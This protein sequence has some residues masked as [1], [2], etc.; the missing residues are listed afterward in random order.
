MQR[1]PSPI[2]TLLNPASPTVQRI[3][4]LGDK[5]IRHKGAPPGL[6]APAPRT[7]PKYLMRLMSSFP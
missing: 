6:K 7:G 4:L 5:S 1:L 2:R 3:G